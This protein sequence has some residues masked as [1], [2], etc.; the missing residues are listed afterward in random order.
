MFTLSRLPEARTLALCLILYISHP[1]VHSLALSNLVV[2]RHSPKSLAR[3][4]FSRVSLSLFF[5]PLRSLG[6]LISSYSPRFSGAEGGKKAKWRDRARSALYT[7]DK[8]RRRRRQQQPCYIRC[9]L[10]LSEFRRRDA[11]A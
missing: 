7:R 2:R 10:S 4:N 5:P 11:A 1:V 3:R 6:N 9:S 8:P